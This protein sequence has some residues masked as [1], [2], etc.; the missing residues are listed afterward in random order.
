[1]ADPRMEDPPDDDEGDGP[2]TGGNP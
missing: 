2:L 1:M